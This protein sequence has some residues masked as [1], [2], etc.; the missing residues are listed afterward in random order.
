M[1][2]ADLIYVVLAAAVFLFDHFVL[3]SCFLRQASV[4][5]GR[6]RLIYWSIW[7][8]LMWALTIGGIDLWH[9]KQRSWADIGF[10]GPHG[11]R[12]GFAAAIVLALVLLYCR[13]G[14]KVARSAAARK[15]LRA[16]YQ[17]LL[18][19][20]PHTYLELG[21]FVA[22]SL[23]AGFCEEFIFRGYL[24][25]FFQPWLSWWGSAALCAIF[26]AL[27]HSYQGVAGILRT[28]ILGLVFVL[29]F[30]ISG[31]LW[32]GIILHALIDIGSGVLGWL[33]VHE[34]FS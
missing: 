17:K 29:V 27:G 26:F 10:V 4:R 11:W 12:L 14:L 28:G 6:A 19:I 34:E 23:T 24:I 2:R 16:T 8:T 3:W 15:K 21:A 13:D 1:T 31:S 5:P 9:T 25:W 22:L 18:V 20:L 33:V 7:M 30:A 32:P